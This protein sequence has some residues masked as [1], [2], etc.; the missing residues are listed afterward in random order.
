MRW[1]NLFVVVL[2]VFLAVGASWGDS[3]ADKLFDESYWE[4]SA[5]QSLASQQ[6][7]GVAASFR[8]IEFGPAAGYLDGGILFFADLTD[9]FLGVSTNIPPIDQ[10]TQR[11]LKLD[12]RWGYGYMF[13]NRDPFTY[14]RMGLNF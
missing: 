13:R 1:C 11:S 7:T 3:V 12:T 14:V 2:L 8:V 9:V 4:L 5:V 10:W 6:G